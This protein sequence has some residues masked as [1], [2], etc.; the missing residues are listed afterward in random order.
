MDSN[1]VNTAERRQRLNTVAFPEEQEGVFEVMLEALFETLFGTEFKTRVETLLETMHVLRG[2]VYS[3][4]L[5]MSPESLGQVSAF[6]AWLLYGGRG[7]ESGTCEMGPLREVLS[8]VSSWG[9]RAGGFLD[10][11]GLQGFN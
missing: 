5:T 2:C 7:L 8:R 11:Y 3:L 9:P 10:C 6:L 1:D 4:S